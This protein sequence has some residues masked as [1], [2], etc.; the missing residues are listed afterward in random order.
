MKMN[1][2]NNILWL[3][4]IGGLLVGILVLLFCRLISTW[5]GL[6][7]NVIIFVGM[8][9]LLYGSYSLWVTTRAPRPL[10]VVTILAFANMGWLAVC[11][12]IIAVNWT[13]IS[14]FGVLHK[15]GEGLFVSILGY[16]EWHWRKSLAAPSG[17]NGA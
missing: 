1:N 7:L 10:K 6:P 16:T 14:T 17:K 12:T 5:D 9:N 8:A 11:I 3:D 13:E 2:R 4:C 15:L